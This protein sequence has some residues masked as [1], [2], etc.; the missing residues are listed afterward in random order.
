VCFVQMY[1]LFKFEEVILYVIEVD[2]PF[3]PPCYYG[4]RMGQ[5]D[6]PRALNREGQ[7]HQ[8]TFLVCVIN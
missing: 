7:A 1:V 6:F 4:A 3:R 5:M 2:R 8:P